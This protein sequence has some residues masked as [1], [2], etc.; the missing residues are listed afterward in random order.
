[1]GLHYKIDVIKA[2]K[3]KGYT[4][5]QFRQNKVFSE[6]TLTKLRKQEAISWDNI[7]TICR[8]LKCQPSK[9]LEYTP[10]VGE[11]FGKSEKRESTEK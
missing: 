2:L 3:E 4:T 8:L 7:E 5:Y 11:G 9:F 10:D 6:S 1:M